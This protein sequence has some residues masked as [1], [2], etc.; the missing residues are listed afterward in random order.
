MSTPGRIHQDDRGLAAVR[1]VRVARENDSRVGLQ[2]ALGE[3]RTTA[4][5]AARA[6]ERLAAAP[7]FAA[8][9]AVEFHV[10]RQVLTA[11]ATD[12][13]ATEDAAAVSDRIADEA[14]RHW[15][16]DRTAVRVADLLLGRRAEARAEE[17]ARREAADLDDLAATGWLRRTTEEAAR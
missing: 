3:R 14:R 8:G 4:D 16:A 7:A 6:Q 5:A 15:V 11:L 17:R 2:Q 1:R 13:R 9:G 12:R 10:H